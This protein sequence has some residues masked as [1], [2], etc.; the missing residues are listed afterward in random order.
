M[1]R[2][3]ALRDIG[4]RIDDTAA[5]A[6][7]DGP[8]DRARRLPKVNA[9]ASGLD[10]AAKYRRTANLSLSANQNVREFSCLV[11]SSFAERTV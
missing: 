11:N 9:R 8:I 10:T 3:R 6:P 4:A 5:R 2:G 7:G 1:R